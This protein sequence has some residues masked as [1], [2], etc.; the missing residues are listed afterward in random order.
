MRRLALI[1]TFLTLALVAAI[2]LPGRP[3]EAQG[4]CYQETGFCIENPL[5]QDYFRVRGGTRILGY[6]VSRSFMLEGNQVQFFQRV[7]LQQS[8]NTVNRLNVLDRD[9]MPMT[10]AN[11]STFPAPDTSLGGAGAIPDPS[12]PDYADRVIDF[13]ATYAPN[14][15]NGQNVG[16]FDLFKGTVPTEIAFPGQIPNPGLVTLLNMEIWGVPT[17]QP[18]PDPANSGFV[19]QRFQRGIMHYRTEQN[20]TEGILVADYLKSVMTLRNLPPDLAE[21]MQGS[22]YFGQY[23]PSAPNW[24]KRPDLLP[25]TNL[26]SAFEPGAG[27]QVSA[28]VGVP[29]TAMPGATST[30]GPAVS[31]QVDDD[32]IDPGDE[33]SV[34]VIARDPRGL[35]WI[36]WEGDDTGDAELDREHRFDCNGQTECANVWQVTATQPGRHTL[37][38]RART[39]DDVESDLMPVTVRVREVS[40]TPVPTTAPTAVPTTAPTSVPTSAPTSAPAA[41]TTPP[42]SA[43]GGT[44]TP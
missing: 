42:T 32:Q 25:N 35:D 21:E 12:S 29:A 40:A 16:F 38:A 43:P 24:V 13:V 2:T 39:T 30:S 33:L 41:P 11:G 3:A 26:T 18:T 15:W 22:R 10:R 9:V 31:I 5:F 19:Y 4:Q 28:P 34:T 6:P 14:Q 37:N 44:A 8:G 20:V 23:D 36:A 1:G 27:G 7:V 17:S